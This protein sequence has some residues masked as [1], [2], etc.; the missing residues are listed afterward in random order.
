LQIKGP[1]TSKLPG[2]A[3]AEQQIYAGLTGRAAA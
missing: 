3:C 2:F 1:F